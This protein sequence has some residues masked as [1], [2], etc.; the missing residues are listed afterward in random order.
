MTRGWMVCECRVIERVC[1]EQVKLLG[2]SSIYV[3]DV[4][5]PSKDRNENWAF[6]HTNLEKKAFKF[7]V[8]L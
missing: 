7:P 3:F 5:D 8:R 2:A 4:T 6:I 1:R